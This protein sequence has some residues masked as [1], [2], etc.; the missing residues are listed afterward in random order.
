M[1]DHKTADDFRDA[2]KGMRGAMDAAI[3]IGEAEERRNEA[4]ATADIVPVVVTDGVAHCPSCG[5]ER[6]TETISVARDSVANEGGKV[7]FQSLE[8][9]GAVDEGEWFFCYSCP[10]QLDLSSCELEYE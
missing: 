1:T 7:T 6:F 4:P 10:Q 5:G 2:L 3:A 8:D 9:G